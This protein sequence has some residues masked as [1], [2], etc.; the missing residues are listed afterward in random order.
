MI[1]ASCSL[2]KKAWNPRLIFYH[3][4]PA[5]EV[6]QQLAD[7]MGLAWQVCEKDLVNQATLCRMR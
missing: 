3:R 5:G 2:A 1:V 7:Q 6:W 4:F